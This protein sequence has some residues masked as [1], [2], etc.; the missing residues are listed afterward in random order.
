MMEAMPTPAQIKKAFH[1]LHKPA[2]EKQPTKKK[3]EVDFN[4]VFDEFASECGRQNGR[5]D[6]T[7]KKFAVVKNHLKNFRDGLIFK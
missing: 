7:S 1:S 5:T 3:A 4:S 6:S 2:G